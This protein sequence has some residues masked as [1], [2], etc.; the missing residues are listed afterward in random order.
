MGF[1]TSSELNGLAL[2]GLGDLL[3]P[4]IGPLTASAAMRTVLVDFSALPMADPLERSLPVIASGALA[5][6]MHYVQL[7]P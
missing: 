6:A 7:M 4:V 1:C 2:A 5:L 3:G